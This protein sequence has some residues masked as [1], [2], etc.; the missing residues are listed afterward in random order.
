V[1]LRLY[2]AYCGQSWYE[3]QRPLCNHT[4]DVV[5]YEAIHSQDGTTER[6]PEPREESQ[7]SCDLKGR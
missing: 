1:K 7:T 3:G 6:Q 5:P 4:E 2:C